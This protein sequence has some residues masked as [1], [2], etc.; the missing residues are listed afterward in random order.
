MNNSAVW[1]LYM[2]NYDSLLLSLHAYRE[3]LG[4]LYLYVLMQVRKMKKKDINILEAGCGTGN[5]LLFLEHLQN[6][7]PGRRIDL[8]GIDRSDFALKTASGKTKKGC[9]FF[10]CELAKIRLGMKDTEYKEFAR[11]SFDLIIINNVLFSLSDR[12]K[13]IF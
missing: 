3:L 12:E 10:Q 1:D 5:M 11:A 6:D 2:K 8:T 4:D 7:A 13:A 9:R